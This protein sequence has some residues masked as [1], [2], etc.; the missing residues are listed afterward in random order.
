MLTPVFPL[1]SPA[2]AE[3]LVRFTP[4]PAK[5]MGRKGGLVAE[6]DRPHSSTLP[7]LCGISEPSWSSR[8]VGWGSVRQQQS[9]SRG[10]SVRSSRRRAE[11]MRIKPV[12][13]ADDAD[14]GQRRV[15]PHRET[16][17]ELRPTCVTNP[18]RLASFVQSHS[19]LRL[20]LRRPSLAHLVVPRPQTAVASLP[21]VGSSIALSPT[22]ISTVESTRARSTS[23]KPT[24]GLRCAVAVPRRPL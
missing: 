3:F 18:A 17:S 19:R 7:W 5:P 14:K 20:V 6:M 10:R 24:V 16:C 13:H 22:R 9:P 1:A 23:P 15:F 12:Y 2:A 4:R 8:L 11:Q 21:T